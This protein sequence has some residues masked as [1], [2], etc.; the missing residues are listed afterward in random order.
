M[1]WDAASGMFMGVLQRVVAVKAGREAV[2]DQAL[3]GADNMLKYRVDSS[4]V[5]ADWWSGGCNRLVLISHAMMRI[6]P[7]LHAGPR[8]RP[9]LTLR[10]R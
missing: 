6:H 2:V 9:H 8:R 1:L 7:P 5:R 3:A 10:A 4:K